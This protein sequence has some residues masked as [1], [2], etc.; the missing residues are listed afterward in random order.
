[1]FHVEHVAWKRNLLATGAAELNLSLADEAILQLLAYAGEL[2]A[3]NR[4]VNLTGVTKEEEV[5]VKHFLDSLIYTQYVQDQPGE[6][7]LDVGAGA[8]FPGLP[9]KIAR[10]GLSVTLLEPS[11]KKTAF[12]HHVIGTLRLE[13]IVAVSRR[14]QEFARDRANWSRFRHIVTRAVNVVELLPYL[15]RLLA[16]G[17]QVVLWRS[18]PLETLP[19][20]S[21]LV[22][23]EEVLY[24][25]PGGYGQRRLVLLGTEETGAASYC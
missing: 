25:L 17:G 12:L 11:A 24:Q 21:G 20:Q 22:V 1:M 4:K 7:L 5:F 2:Q 19:R 9:L 16:P 3:W 13:R 8:G 14:V 15:S 18:Q 10:P 6:S 23:L